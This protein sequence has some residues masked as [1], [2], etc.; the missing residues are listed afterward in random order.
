[1]K[2]NKSL[3]LLL[4]FW[5]YDNRQMYLFG[6]KVSPDERMRAIEDAQDEAEQLKQSDDFKTND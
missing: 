6:E 2:Y 5:E 3:Q 4:P 1:M